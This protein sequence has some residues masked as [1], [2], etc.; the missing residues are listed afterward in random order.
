MSIEP[1]ESNNDHKWWPSD[2]TNCLLVSAPQ[3]TDRDF[4]GTVVYLCEHSTKGAM[5][6]VINRTAGINLDELCQQAGMQVRRSNNTPVLAGGPV[7]RNQGFVLY[8]SDTVVKDSTHIIADLYRSSSWKLLSEIVNGR[9][10][11]RFLVAHGCAGWAPSQLEA[12]LAVNLW[13]VCPMDDKI[14]FDTPSDRRLDAVMDI[15][16]FD[17]HLLS[18]ESGRA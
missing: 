11:S 12:E 8:S 6:L 10:P 7:L 14:L 9:G 5:G 13:L 4:F 3:I 18:S 2:L 15:L 16:G 1:K 17:Y